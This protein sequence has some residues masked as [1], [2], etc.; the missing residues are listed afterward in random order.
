MITRLSSPRSVETTVS[1]IEISLT[2]SKSGISSSSVDT[3]TLTV[4]ISSG[5]KS[6]ISSILMTGSG[7]V[8]GDSS[9]LVVELSPF[10]VKTSAID[11]TAP[12][13]K[14]PNPLPFFWG[15]VGAS[16]IAFIP[17]P[18]TASYT[19]EFKS[20]HSVLLSR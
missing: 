15:C 14:P 18:F 9:L 20:S 13:K 4:G 19:A 3:L 1:G 5:G 2:L 7:R 10:D 11:S 17:K 6:S 12:L 8:D 16:T